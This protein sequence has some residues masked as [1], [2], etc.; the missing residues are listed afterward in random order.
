[1]ATNTLIDWRTVDL[2]MPEVKNVENPNAIQER[3]IFLPS[4]LEDNPALTGR[5]PGYEQRLMKRDPKIA[6]ALRFGN[7]DVFAGQMFSQFSRARHVITP[8]EIPLT[9]SRLRAI[10]WGFADPFACYFIAI[11]PANKQ[12]IVYKEIYKSGLSDP[13]QAEMVRSYEQ[14]GESFGFNFAD[15]SMWT[16]RTTEMVAK[17]TYDVYIEHGV[18]LTKA[19]NDNRSKIAKTHSILAD[20]WYGQPGVLIFNTVTNLINTLGALV[21]DENNPEMIKD[22]QEDHAW[23]AFAYSLTNWS[24]DKP[25]QTQ[26]QKP[27]PFTKM[28]GL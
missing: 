24:D 17:S 15:P 21:R 2:E 16:R 9:W 12:R 19:D 6:Q 1:M 27:N 20:Q 22:G 13:A 11:N 18:L 25:K 4:F 23:D 26:E 7:W 14:I 8:F 10:D 3:T 28:K 5:D